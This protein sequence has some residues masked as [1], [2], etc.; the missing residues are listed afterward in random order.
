MTRLRWPRRQP[1]P[2]RNVALVLG[3]GT[4]IPVDCAYVGRRDRLHQ[5]NVIPPPGGWPTD[6]WSHVTIGVLPGRTAVTCDYY[7]DGVL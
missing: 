2:P 4:R 5:W 7:T 3:D 6:R 1:K